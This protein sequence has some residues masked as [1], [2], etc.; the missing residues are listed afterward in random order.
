MFSVSITREA[1]SGGTSDSSATL[2]PADLD[3]VENTRPLPQ[4]LLDNNRLDTRTW[5]FTSKRIDF[6]RHC[7]FECLLSSSW[8]QTRSFQMDSYVKRES[9]SECGWTCFPLITDLCVRGRLLILWCRRSKLI[10]YWVIFHRGKKS[11]LHL[12]VTSCRS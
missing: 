12:W 7:T 1:V 5:C 8:K 3:A 9:T 4:F 10:S 6:Q 11:A 2:S